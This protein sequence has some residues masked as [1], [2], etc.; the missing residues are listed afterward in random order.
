[1][2]LFSGL[3]GNLEKYIEGFFKDKFKSRVQP[4]EIAKQLA[5]EMRNNRRISVSNTY[6]PNEYTVILHP[7]DWESIGAFNQLLSLELQD[8][9]LQKAEEKGFTLVGQPLV[10]VEKNEETA[11]G[12]IVV[13]ANFGEA[14]PV[15]LESLRKEQPVVDEAEVEHT[16][17]FKPIKETAPLPKPDVTP[18]RL[19]VEAGRDAG[20]FFILNSQQIDIGRRELNDIVLKDPSVSRIH[21]QIEVKDDTYVLTDLNSTNGTYVNDVRIS[22]KVLKSGDTIVFGTTVCTFKVDP[23]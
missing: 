22:Q 9:L 23:V 15:N 17:M 6:V 7:E 13:K 19:T 11:A 1:M 21:A 18:A 4:V 10:T 2:G 5:R 8:Y 16:Q 3:E 12:N 14:V 20:K